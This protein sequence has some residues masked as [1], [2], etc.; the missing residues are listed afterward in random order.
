MKKVIRIVFLQVLVSSILCL[1]SCNSNVESVMG[2]YAYKASGQLTYDGLRE[3]FYEESGELEFI[4]LQK[5]SVLL[6]FVATEGGVFTT[7]ASVEGNKVYLSPCSRMLSLSY[8]ETDKGI[9]TGTVNRT[10]TLNFKVGVYGE[11]S[12]YGESILFELQYSGT[13]LESGNKL[14]GNQITMVAKKKRS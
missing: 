13:E 9:L 6:S 14:R 4:Y 7:T 8:T 5:D 3:F 1:V 11:G 12:I 10:E 2:E